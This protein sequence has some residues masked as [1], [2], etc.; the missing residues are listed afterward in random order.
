VEVRRSDRPLPT[1]TSGHT[2]PGSPGGTPRDLAARRRLAEA[3]KVVQFT[4]ATPRDPSVGA[5]SSVVVDRR[6]SGGLVALGYA[7]FTLIE[8]TAYA[9]DPEP[10]GK[11]IDPAARVDRVIVNGSPGLWIAGAHEIAYLDRTGKFKTD[12]VRRS[13]SVLLWAQA[14]VTYR[15][16][17]FSALADAQRVAAS[18]R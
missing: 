9:A 18:I 8:V 12:T 11:V 13:G 17:G 7:R 15:I 16:E 6:V 5:L 1:G 3:R 10:V 4:I 14:G 2:V